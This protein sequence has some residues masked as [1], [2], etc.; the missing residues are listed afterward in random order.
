MLL[1]GDFYD[2]AS[3]KVGQQPRNP[4]GKAAVAEFGLERWRYGGYYEKRRGNNRK[5]NAWH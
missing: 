5:A 1:R 3:S 2:F 4:H